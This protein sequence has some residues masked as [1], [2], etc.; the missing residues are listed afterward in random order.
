MVGGIQTY[1]NGLSPHVKAQVYALIR[2]RERSKGRDG[3]MSPMNAGLRETVVDSLFEVE[4]RLESQSGGRPDHPL[5]VA[6]RSA[7]QRVEFDLGWSDA[8]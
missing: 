8:I 7:R 2:T 4:D 5:V 6:L 1:L 3:S